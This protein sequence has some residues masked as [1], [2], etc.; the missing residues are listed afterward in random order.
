MTYCK[1]WNV[2]LDKE[3]GNDYD[4]LQRIIND[5]NN[6]RKILC[7]GQYYS[8]AKFVRDKYH[9]F[10]TKEDIYNVTCCNAYPKICGGNCCRHLRYIDKDECGCNIIP[11][12]ATRLDNCYEDCC[13]FIRIKNNRKFYISWSDEYI[14]PIK[15][16][17]RKY[18]DNK[19]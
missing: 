5:A 4:M 8:C 14:A 13:R 9:K 17:D 15:Y 16:Q 19:Y 6:K 7:H 10:F 18:K 3:K 11:K 2:A 1:R 12:R